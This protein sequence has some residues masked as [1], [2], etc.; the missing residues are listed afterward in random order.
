MKVNKQAERT[1]MNR[2]QELEQELHSNS[3]KNQK[4]ISQGLD[5]IN[6]L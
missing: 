5:K 6:G 4:I 3:C 1:L 2:I